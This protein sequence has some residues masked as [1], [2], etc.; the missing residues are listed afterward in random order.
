MYNVLPMIKYKML[1][2]AKTQGFC[3]STKIICK[4]KNWS[5]YK[6]KAI[7]DSREKPFKLTKSTQ[8]SETLLNDVSIRHNP[9]G[10]PAAPTL[11]LLWEIK[12]A[13]RVKAKLEKA[14]VKVTT[15]CLKIYVLIWV[16]AQK[17]RKRKQTP[18]KKK[19]EILKP[20][21]LPTFPLNLT[22]SVSTLNF[23]TKLVRLLKRGKAKLLTVFQRN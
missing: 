3:N 5:T 21:P 6:K 8:V 1:I 9:S 17:T 22:R 2:Y 18:W 11:P 20:M 14:L 13:K 23:K 15:D 4:H 12:K 19:P 7:Q 10:L 16:K